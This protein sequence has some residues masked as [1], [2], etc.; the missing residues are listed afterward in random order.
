MSTNQL[1]LENPRGEPVCLVIHPVD[2]QIYRLTP[3]SPAGKCLA[4]YE[5]VSQAILR[6][7]TGSLGGVLHTLPRELRYADLPSESL[8]SPE[9]WL[10]LAALLDPESTYALPTEEVLFLAKIYRA[11]AQRHL[12][13]SEALCNEMV[14]AQAERALAELGLNQDEIVLASHILFSVPGSLSLVP[15]RLDPLTAALSAARAVLA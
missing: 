8:L 6:R 15:L 5:Y 3:T 4:P 13:L 9:S 10:R 7:V 12:A 1:L 2:D 11:L 14:L